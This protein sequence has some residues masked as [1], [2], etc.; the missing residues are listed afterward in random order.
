VLVWSA[1][2]VIGARSD[3][4]GLL[5]CVGVAV[6]FGVQAFENVG[7]NLGI[8]PVTGLPLPFPS[9][10]ARRCSPPGWL[11]GWST[12][13]TSRARAGAGVSGVGRL[14]HPRGRDG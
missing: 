9:S 12:T 7:M 14:G 6:W 8:V 11:C 1:T 10:A 3:P 13:S 2:L 4:F 5:V